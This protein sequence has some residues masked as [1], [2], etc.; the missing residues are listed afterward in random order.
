MGVVRELDLHV[1]IDRDVKEWLDGV[2]TL[3]GAG[4]GCGCGHGKGQERCEGDELELHDGDGW[5]DLAWMGIERLVC[6]DWMSTGDE[7]RTL[8]YEK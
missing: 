8:K 1:S 5:S 3:D 2:F 7:L 6:R 4:F